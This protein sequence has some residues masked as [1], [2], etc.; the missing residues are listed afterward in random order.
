VPDDLAPASVTLS[1]IDGASSGREYAFSERTTAL[2]GRAEDCEPRIDKAETQVSR[3]HCLFDI[4]PP[5]LRVRD[6]G[7]LNGTHVNGV[8]IGRRRPGQSPAEGARLE[9]R[10]R[11]LV[12]GDEVRLG[13]TVMRVGV[14]LAEDGPRVAAS[15]EARCAQCG[16]DVSGQAGNRR[17]EIVCADCKRDPRAIVAG[18]LRKAA[19]GDGALSAIRG[20]EI[21]SELGRGGQGVV[22]LARHE[23][24]GELVALK[25]LLAEVAVERKARD[26]FLREI[27]STKALRHPNVVEFRDSG[28]SGATFFLAS[29]YCDGGSVDRLQVRR[30]GTLSVEEAVPIVLQ[31]LEGLEYAHSAPVPGVRPA[32]GAVGDSRG[33]VHRDIKPANILLAGTGSTRVAKLADFGLAKAFDQAG[34]SGH[35]RTGSVGG[36]VAFMARAQIVS[37]RFA[38]PEVDVWAVAASLYWML[39]S[40]AP[41]DFPAGVDPIA[42]ILR[43]RAVPIRTRDRSIPH[44]LAAVVDE[45][46]IDNPRITVTTAADL[47]AALRGAV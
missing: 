28:S 45:A 3:H 20:Y 19:S 21:V 9:F 6:F 27:E 7:S 22:Y 26:G 8:E 5:D 14:T 29:E 15:E 31:V 25:V 10:E 33:L 23:G 41:R 37:Y 1:V 35:T 34:L 44:Q 18:L 12:H 43:S 17:G 30:G 32:G 24:F 13:K 2:V 39:T 16:R 11:D 38:K 47:A 46:L 42:A 36:T 4:N 40:K